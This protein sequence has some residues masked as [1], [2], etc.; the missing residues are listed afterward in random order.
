VFTN[1][2]IAIR[3]LRLRKGWSQETLGARARV[4]REAVS[5]CERSELDGMTLGLV[6]QIASALGATVS[7][8]LRWQ[9]EQLDRL[10]D[11]AHAAMQQ[12]V[13]EWLSS[14]GWRARV[15]VSFNHYGDRGRVDIL[16]YHPLRQ[17]LLVVEIKSGL[18]DLQETIGRLDVKARV[19]RTV[20]RELGWTE[21]DA[22]VPAL[23][24]GDARAARR[25]V[26]AHDALFAAFNLRGRAAIAWV[27]RPRQPGPT[28]LLWF[29]N[30]KDSRQLTDRRARRRS[31]PVE[32][33]GA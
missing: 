21:I 28:G 3:A 1:V 12:A 33:H 14:L 31:D 5:R 10:I 6:A 24:I 26:T 23:V 29:T 9:G 19:A 32:S 4:S 18:G 25:T 27:A 13:A 15:E 2:P 11:A 7:V 22:V 8:Q 20:A 30:R 17:I 16:A